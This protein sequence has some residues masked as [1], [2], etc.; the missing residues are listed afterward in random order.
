MTANYDRIARFY[1]VDMAQNMPFDDVG[2]YADLCA[3]TGGPVLEL[4]CGNG[5]I[6]L[7]L[8]ERG[9]DAWGV[10]ASAQM[11]NELQRKAAARGIECHTELMDIRRLALRRRFDTIVCPYSL[12]TY[13]TED[14][15]LRL[16]MQAVRAHLIPGGRLVM[17]AFIPKAV[18]SFGDFRLDY[19]RAFGE[20]T[21]A[22]FK[23]I[24]SLGPALNRIE[25]RYQVVDARGEIVEQIDVSET[26][27]PFT[28]QQLRDLYTSSG[29]KIEAEWLDYGESSDAATARFF[30][31]SGSC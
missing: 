19:R 9:I 7:R 26:I 8:L 24:Q 29:M 20:A 10:D 22:R 5:R 12:I 1:D 14:D 6:L 11:L 3:T 13:V 4:G 15:D 31:L 17:D 28:P 23:R 21:L 16:L 2:F 27:R 25:R 30:T 18:Q